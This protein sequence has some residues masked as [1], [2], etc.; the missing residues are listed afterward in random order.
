MPGADVAARVGGHVGVARVP[1]E[2]DVFFRGDGGRVLEG[3]VDFG[4]RPEVKV[5]DGDC[6]DAGREGVRLGM[7][8]HGCGCGYSSLKWWVWVV[9]CC[10]GK[11]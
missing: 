5:V 11:I 3:V 7:R 6:V 1:E 9:R 4:V 10:S 8:L 2:E